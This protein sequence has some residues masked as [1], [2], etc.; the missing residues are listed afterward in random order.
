MLVFAS[1]NQIIMRGEFMAKTAYNVLHSRLGP[2]KGC[3]PCSCHLDPYKP[4]T[5]TVSTHTGTQFWGSHG[6]LVKS[7]TIWCSNCEKSLTTNVED[8]GI[9]EG[10]LPF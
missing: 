8:D 9:Y 6:A 2:F 3:E 10:D 4:P 7:V 1:V 5:Y